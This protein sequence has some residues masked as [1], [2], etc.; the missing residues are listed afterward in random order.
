MTNWSKLAELPVTEEEI[1]KGMVDAIK[2]ME[3]RTSPEFYFGA[4]NKQTERKGTNMGKL[5]NIVYWNN[6]AVMA[7]DE[8]GEQMPDL[9]SNLI[10]DHLRKLNDQGV[11]TEDTVVE[12][13][14]NGKKEPAFSSTTFHLERKV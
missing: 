8:G 6:G 9:Q 7:F 13:Q 5:R 3:Y 11:I 1:L 2:V 10:A 4:F 14:F 12:L